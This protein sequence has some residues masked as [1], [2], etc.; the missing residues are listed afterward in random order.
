MG[1]LVSLSVTCKREKKRAGQKNCAMHKR[2]HLSLAKK[3]DVFHIFLLR[4]A[5]APKIGLSGGRGNVIQPHSLQ[6]GQHMGGRGSEEVLCKREM[7]PL[8]YA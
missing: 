1:G 4:L 6:I 7:R 2:M 3:R 8:F 5:P